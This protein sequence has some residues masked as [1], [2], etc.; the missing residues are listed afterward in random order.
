[1]TGFVSATILEHSGDLI[2][3]VAD[4]KVLL[5]RSKFI[6]SNYGDQEIDN[7]TFDGDGPELLLAAVPAIQE[8]EISEESAG[9]HGEFIS[10]SLAEGIV[11]SHSTTLKDHDTLASSKHI[12]NRRSSFNRETDA[13]AMLDSES[14]SGDSLSAASSSHVYSFFQCRT[15]CL[16]DL[17][18]TIER[19]LS[20]GEEM[21]FKPPTAR[22]AFSV[23]EAA[24]PF[25]LKICG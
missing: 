15:E 14:D 18:P 12:S 7:T 13:L 11:G 22:V 4:L 9:P 1:M 3:Q 20:H 16:M 5:Q 23:T 8:K 10:D 25:V 21:I 6:I 19:C 2:T 17:V 24:R